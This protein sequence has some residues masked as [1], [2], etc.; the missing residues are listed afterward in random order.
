MVLTS[1]KRGWR[2]SSTRHNK[3]NSME[4][5]GLGKRAGSSWS[6]AVSKIRGG[7]CS[8]FI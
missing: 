1:R 8:L 4:L 5:P 2:T 6:P 3:D 7:G